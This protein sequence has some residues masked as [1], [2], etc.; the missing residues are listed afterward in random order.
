MT[1]RHRAYF[2]V[3]IE[4]FLSGLG[5]SVALHPSSSCLAFVDVIK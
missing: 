3:E 2:I 1:Y 5:I 4:W